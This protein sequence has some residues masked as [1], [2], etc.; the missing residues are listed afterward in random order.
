MLYSLYQSFHCNYRC[1]VY[2]SPGDSCRW[3]CSPLGVRVLQYWTVTCWWGSTGFSE[4]GDT[5]D[6]GCSLLYIKQWMGIPKKNILQ[7]WKLWNASPGHFPNAS[8]WWLQLKTELL[9][10]HSSDILYFRNTSNLAL[11]NKIQTLFDFISWKFFNH[12]MV[13]DVL[14]VCVRVYMN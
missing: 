3:S 4:Y 2:L 9:P 13:D 7:W 11:I 12:Q 8:K 10:N 1:V 6:Q 14:Y 5:F